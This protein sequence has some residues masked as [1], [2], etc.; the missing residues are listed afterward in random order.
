MGGQSDG[1]GWVHEIRAFYR[2]H[3]TN[4]LSVGAQAMWHFLMVKANDNWWRY[5]ICLNLTEIACGINHSLTS[6]KRSRE[7]L[8]CRGLISWDSHGG[9]SAASYYV[10]SLVGARY[11]GQKKGGFANADSS[12]EHSSGQ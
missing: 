12:K 1:T 11:A 4:R 9:R 10:Y 5:P 2:E 8:T 7:E 6:V 3:N